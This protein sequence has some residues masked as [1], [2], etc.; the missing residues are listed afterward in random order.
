M[1]FNRLLSRAISFYG[2]TGDRRI[3]SAIQKKILPRLI[4]KIMKV[5]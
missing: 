5:L 4:L 3:E 1:E 2:E